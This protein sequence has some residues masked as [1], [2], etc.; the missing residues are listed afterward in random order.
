[1]VMEKHPIYDLPAPT[2]A[3]GFCKLLFI[4]YLVP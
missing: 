4:Q 2:H 3:N 1:M